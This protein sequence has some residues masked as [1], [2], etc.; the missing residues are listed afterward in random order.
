MSLVELMGL[1][2]AG[3]AGW[4]AGAGAPERR[5]ATRTLGELTATPHCGGIPLRLDPAGRSVTGYPT[6]G[7]LVHEGGEGSAPLRVRLR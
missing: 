3:P 4:I 5:F 7:D 1:R 6:W 2:H